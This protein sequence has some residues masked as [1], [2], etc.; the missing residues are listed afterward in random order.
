MTSANK[1]RALQEAL[2]DTSFA[3]FI[4]VPINFVLALVAVNNDWS[5]TEM[6]IYFT[7]VFYILAIYRKYRVRLYFAKKENQ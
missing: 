3:T 1:K 6:T 5:P 2:I 4:S 7:S